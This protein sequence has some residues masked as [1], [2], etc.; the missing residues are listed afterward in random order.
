MTL[1]EVMVALVILAVGLLALSGMQMAAIRANGSGFNSTT[2]ASLADQRL[3]Q[4]KDDALSF[5][6]GSL[7]VGTHAEADVTDSMNMV[8][9]QSYTVADNNPITGVK[10]IT[11]TVSWTDRGLT[12]RVSLM[13]RKGNADS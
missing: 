8:Y 5:S 1:L 7:T 2:A 4:L 10:L 11:Y 13:S 3:E 6:D 12:H 9:T